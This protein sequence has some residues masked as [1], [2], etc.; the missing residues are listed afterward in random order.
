M[1]EDHVGPFEGFTIMKKIQSKHMIKSDNRVKAHTRG[2]LA[3]A[4][5]VG[6]LS[7]SSP[8]MAYTSADT[9]TFGLTE[10]E[11]ETLTAVFGYAPSEAETA[12]YLDAFGSVPTEAQIAAYLAAEGNSEAVSTDGIVATDGNISM[13]AVTFSSFFKSGSWI[14]RDGLIS[15]SLMPRDGGIGNEGADRTWNTV[16]TR[17]SSSS[18]WKNTSVM[19]QQ[20][21]CH[22]WYGMI[23]TPWNLEPS[24]TSINPIT[25]N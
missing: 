4:L 20:Y 24:R 14:T 2:L 7:V 18:N 6:L 15:L 11:E 23:K 1:I 16:K 10:V 17:F 5:V 21:N 12:Q 13:R 8:A 25:C 3:G 9:N 19:Q 22:F